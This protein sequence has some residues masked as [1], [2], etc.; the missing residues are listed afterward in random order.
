MV[1]SKQRH[2]EGEEVSLEVSGEGGFQKER[3]VPSKRQA[4][5]VPCGP[6]SKEANETTAK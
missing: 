5:R 4:R 3:R 6:D 2:E 1:R